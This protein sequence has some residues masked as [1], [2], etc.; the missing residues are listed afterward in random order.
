MT[1]AA[2]YVD[3]RGAYAGLAGV[4]LWDEAR[5]RADLRGALAGGGASAVCPLGSLLERWAVG[6]LSPSARS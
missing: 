3:P 1:V 2:L 5:G 6:E 4:E